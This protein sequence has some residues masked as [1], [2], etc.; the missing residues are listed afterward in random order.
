MLL[1]H[2]APSCGRVACRM[3]DP[4]SID[5]RTERSLLAFLRRQLGGGSVCFAAKPHLIASGTE[6]RIIGFSLAGDP[7]FSAPLVL[8]LSVDADYPLQPALELAVHHVVVEQGFPAPP[9]YFHSRDGAELERPFLIMGDM[10]RRAPEGRCNRWCRRLRALLGRSRPLDLDR[11]GPPPAELL[12]KAL[13]QLHSLD[14]E[15]LLQ[16]F[17]RAE[18][19]MP[20]RT[21]QRRYQQTHDIVERW[22]L[23]LLQPLMG[24]LREKRPA[25]GRLAICHGDPHVGNLIISGSRVNAMVDWSGAQLGAPEADLGLICGYRRCNDVPAPGKTASDLDRDLLHSYGR[26]R[27]FDEA[28]VRYYEAELL[29]SFMA[30]VGDQHHRR[31]AGMGPPPNPIL[32][33]PRTMDRLGTRLR[34]LVPAWVPVPVTCV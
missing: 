12:V 14:G 5:S 30:S 18:V 21:G 15:P 11:G 8:R 22:R 27:Q 9:V 34:Q 7:R 33:D 4:V 10:T 32:D 13:A 3:K 16:A 19:P 17:E 23:H 25:L 20:A 24:W 26:Y 2:T 31:L 1:R 6:A 29:I 28:R